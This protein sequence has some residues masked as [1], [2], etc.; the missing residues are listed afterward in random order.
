MKKKL[1]I[2]ITAVGAAVLSGIFFW[3]LMM[4]MR[5]MDD[6]VYDLSMTWSQESEGAPDDWVYDQKGW[7]VF[8]QEGDTITELEPDG[9]GSFFA[10]GEPGQT[11][12]YSRVMTEKLDDATIQAGGADRN[13]AVF[14]DGMLLYTDCP[15]LDNRIGALHLP[16]SG[17]SREDVQVKLPSDYVGKTLTIAQS[18]EPIPDFP[19]APSLDSPIKVYP[20]AVTLYSGYAYE[21]SLIA[22]SFQ[23]AVPTALIFAMGVVLLGAM[24]WQAVSRIPDIHLLF[25]SLTAFL[26]MARE[27][28]RAPFFY[29]YF[30]ASV[31]GEQLVQ[32]VPL[33]VLLLFVSAKLSSWR[34]IAGW[35]V[36]AVHMAVLLAEIILEESGHLTLEFIT[37]SPAAGLFGLLTVLGLTFLEWKQK[38]LFGRLFSVLSGAG[39]VLYWIVV[40]ACAVAGHSLLSFVSMA[41]FR[42]ILQMIMMLA[43]LI[44]VAAEFVYGEVSRRLET[45]L[46]LQRSELTQRN[47]ESI[48]RQH[49]EILMLRHDMAKH[50]HMLRRM[51]QEETVAEYLDSLIGEQ[52]KIHPVLQS[53]NEI[54]DIILNGKLMEAS[55]VG[56]EIRI[57]NG[58]APEKLMVPDKDL[59]ALLM[60]VMDN[61][62]KAAGVSGVS[63][64][65]IELD[66]HISGNF[67]VFTCENPTGHEEPKS[68]QQGLG[69]KIMQQITARY[70]I[71][72]ESR[73]DTDHYMVTVAIPLM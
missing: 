54:V 64:P 12:Y 23:T 73:H 29:R 34:R 68:K 6:A 69:L 25:V 5:P 21:S 24:V 60:N 1:R 42:N 9:Y 48:Q 43:G 53:G 20:L 7:T 35:C 61:A 57:V 16:M 13:I 38:K 62:V 58:S 47:Y 70:G 33:F 56:I 45:Q 19:D 26:W 63:E 10:L 50:M 31:P 65:Y 11:F 72:M 44:A 49:E 17:F 14:L 22:E 40:A 36:A 3:V 2:G 71:L 41:Y 27:M 15:E 18:T 8:T 51:T 37:W 59:C 4:Y 46:L 30:G 32:D 67:F 55:E 39:V 28:L 52:K 66:L